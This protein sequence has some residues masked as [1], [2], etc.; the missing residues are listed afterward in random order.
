MSRESE[1]KLMIKEVSQAPRRHENGLR[2]SI[3]LW[4]FS[5]IADWSPSPSYRPILD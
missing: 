2:A 3:G 1:W 4:L 5:F